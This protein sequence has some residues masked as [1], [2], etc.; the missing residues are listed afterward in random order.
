VSTELE[1]KMQYT[2]ETL[3]F[4]RKR[5]NL[6]MSMRFKDKVRLSGFSPPTWARWL[7]GERHPSTAT[8]EQLAESLSVE[9]PLLDGL[10]PMEILAG[11]L[12]IRDRTRE[13]R[14]AA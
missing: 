7:N 14:K 8:L 3:E 10:N 1:R 5:V 9:D 13:K 4:S 6:F 11:I 2:P 12:I